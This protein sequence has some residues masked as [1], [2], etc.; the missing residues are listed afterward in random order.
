MEILLNN[1]KIKIQLAKKN[2]IIREY[3]KKQERR[4]NRRKIKVQ[5]VIRMVNINNRADPVMVFKQRK[6]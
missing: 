1:T 4:L 3:R 5:E 6:Q 2:L